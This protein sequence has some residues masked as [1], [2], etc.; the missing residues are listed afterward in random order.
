MNRLRLFWSFFLL[1]L[2]PII[3]NAYDFCFENSDGIPIYYNDVSINEYLPEVEVAYTSSRYSGE[4]TI[5]DK[6]GKYTVI[7]IGQYAF[8]HHDDLVTINLPQTLQYIGSYAFRDCFSLKNVNMNE[9]LVEIGYQ[10]FYRCIGLEDVYITSQLVSNNAFDYCTKLKKITFSSN[11]DEVASWAFND[12]KNIKTVIFEEGEGVVFLGYGGTSS[13]TKYGLFYGMDLDSVYIGRGIN[14]SASSRYHNPFYNAGI[15]QPDLGPYC[16][17]IPPYWYAEA[18]KQEIIIPEYVSHVAAYAFYET[19]VERIVFP[20]SLTKIGEEAFAY[21]TVKEI[22]QTESR[23]KEIGES[24]F[25]GCVNLQGFVLSEGLTEIAPWVFH[26]CSSLET[27]V[28]PESVV[29]I[30]SGAFLYCKKLKNVNIP[31]GLTTLAVNAF[32][33]TA[34]ESFVCPSGVTSLEAGLFSGCSQLKTVMLHPEI[35]SI[36]SRAF[37]DCIS[38]D[39]VVVPDG[40]TEIDDEV[41]S[42]CSNLRF[43]N[44][45][46]KVTRIGKYAFRNCTS[47]TNIE[48]PEH[49]E[50]LEE[51]AFEGSGLTKFVFPKSIK[52]LRSSTHKN[53]LNLKEVELPTVI[54][55]ELGYSLNETFCGCSSLESIVIP[56]S[57]WWIDAAF[58]GCKNLRKVYIEDAERHLS[59]QHDSRGNGECQSLFDMCPLDSIYIGRGISYSEYSDSPL[60]AGQTAIKSVILKGNV[61]TSGAPLFSECSIGKVLI[62]STVDTIQADAFYRTIPDTL[63]C[64]SVLPIGMALDALVNSLVIVPPGSGMSY[65]SHMAWSK[66]LIIDV[67]DTISVVRVKYPGTIIASMKQSGIMNPEEISK[68]KIEGAI[69]LSD[70]DVLKSEF[71]YLYYL[72]LSSTAIDSIPSNQFSSNYKLNDI[73]LPENINSI[74]DY[75][76]MGCRNFR[77][78]NL[79]LPTCTHVG[80][81]AFAGSYVKGIGFGNAVV[82]ESG[83]LKDS[84]VKNVCF[85]QNVNIGEESFLNCKDL[86]SVVFNGAECTIGESAFSGCEKLYSLPLP[87]NVGNIGVRAFENCTGL[88]NIQ[89]PESGVN[90]DSYAFYGCSNLE[91]L[92][93]QGK[94]C[95]VNSYAFAKTGIKSLTISEGV[96]SIGEYAFS[97][98]YNLEGKVVL[99]NSIQQISKGLFRNCPQIETVTLSDSVLC[100]NVDAFYGCTNLR[101]INLPSTLHTIEQGAFEGCINLEEID[102]PWGLVNFNGAFLNSNIKKLRTHWQV[103][104][105]ISETTFQ[106]VDEDQCLLIVPANSAVNYMTSDNWKIFWNIEEVESELVEKVLFMDPEVEK[107]C[108]NNWDVNLD[109]KIG[110]DELLQVKSLGTFFSANKN[111]K[112]FEELSYFSQ[113]EILV[114]STFSGC[115]NLTSISFP[116]SVSTIGVRALDGCSLVSVEL[117]NSITSIEDYAFANNTQLSN[118]TVHW[119]TP[120]TVN[121]NVFSNVDI[122]VATLYVPEGTKTLYK[123]AAVWKNFGKIIEIGSEE[124]Y[125]L[126]DSNND[127]Y[128]DVADLAAVVKFVLGTA[129]SNLIMEAADMDGSGVV[130]VNDYVALVNVILKQGSVATRNATDMADAE[131]LLQML[132]LEIDEDGM[133]ELRIA[134]AEGR[135]M[136]TGLQ[137]DLTLPDGMAIVDEGVATGSRKHNVWCEQR[138]ANSYR[139]LCSSM[140]SSVFANDTVLCIKVKADA[141]AQG[142]HELTA[143]NVVLSDKEANRYNARQ[144]R[145]ELVIDASEVG[146]TI[147]AERGMLTLRANGDQQVRIALPNGMTVEAIKLS[148]GETIVRPLPRGIYVINGKKVVL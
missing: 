14:Y 114:E 43:V 29:S 23:I 69:N 42:G 80:K 129:G 74:G 140:S 83:A 132:A 27:L 73:I 63:V 26:G 75:A 11:V 95:V 39:T 13:E 85:Q 100:I 15:V 10:S 47:L 44:I 146:L 104:L 91:N 135:Q 102:I 77:R 109:G 119:K 90:I 86:E 108:L 121:S 1:G 16:T 84:R 137:L 128:I 71:P 2:V 51:Y 87:M 30:G 25:S 78:E 113:L 101:S 131:Q 70:W 67:Q 148:D 147:K 103:P 19:E 7:G 55:G 21:S 38:L 8:D 99:P 50:Y 124:E 126:G 68:L 145:R 127:G 134:L 34:I 60:F 41:F 56:S 130:E 94:N 96:S 45:P 106:G 66:N 144:M 24:A 22:V 82:L 48:L 116:T 61:N 46:K 28:L 111:I 18:K 31:K 139:I 125:D 118:I 65:R 20:P 97:D 98:C 105:P 107:I 123:N 17:I 49:L 72:D 133:G 110:L 54:N 57:F 9:H 79:F 62:S 138:D 4:L 37:Q 59:L 117:P 88:S 58:D 33:S 142:T 76:F 143:D 93:L 64:Q 120:L 92:E 3:A 35:N 40:V 112:E 122:T 136:F 12:S 36:G 6:V 89:I 115:T 52:W 5:P 53:C 141:M 32:T 81:E